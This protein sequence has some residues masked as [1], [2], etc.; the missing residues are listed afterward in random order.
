M[1][2]TANQRPFEPLKVNDLVLIKYKRKYILYQLESIEENALYVPP[3]YNSMGLHGG[4]PRQVPILYVFKPI[5]NRDQLKPSSSKRRRMPAEWIHNRATNPR[6]RVEPYA[7]KL[8][9]YIA[10]YEDQLNIYKQTFVNF[11]TKINERTATSKV[12]EPRRLSSI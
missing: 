8:E 2:V 9:D 12:S 4:N 1:D 5:L 10:K 11:Y 7:I 3:T 6:S